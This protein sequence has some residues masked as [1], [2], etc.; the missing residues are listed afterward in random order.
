MSRPV[1][2]P[3][4]PR[5]KG[6]EASSVKSSVTV[7]NWGGGGS[8]ASVA[9]TSSAYTP[10]ILDAINTRARGGYYPLIDLAAS[11]KRVLEFIGNNPEIK[12]VITKVTEELSEI[13]RREKY[14]NPVDFVDYYIAQMLCLSKEEVLRD[15]AGKVCDLFSVTYPH[16]SPQLYVPDNAKKDLFVALSAMHRRNSENDHVTT[17]LASHSMLFGSAEERQELL[18]KAADKGYAPA[19]FLLA[20]SNKGSGWPSEEDV[21]LLS[22]AAAKGY[23]KAQYELGR[24]YE[25]RIPEVAYKVNRVLEAP[26]RA[27]GL[28]PDGAVHKNNEAAVMLF[29]LASDSGYAPAVLKVGDLRRAADMGNPDAQHSLAKSLSY[30]PLR[31]G[32][33][34]SEEDSTLAIIIAADLFRQKRARDIIEKQSLLVENDEVGPFFYS[35]DT[36]ST[37]NTKLTADQIIDVI[38]ILGKT[39]EI[40]SKRIAQN[41]STLIGDLVKVSLP[42]LRPDDLLRIYDG[43]RAVPGMDVKDNASCKAIDGMINPVAVL[44]PLAT[45]GS[46]SAAPT[47]SS[48]APP[49]SDLSAVSAVNPL[50]EALSMAL[51]RSGGSS[52]G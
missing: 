12:H 23:A 48:A 29:K 18:T 22:E 33:S 14:E 35:V 40:A 36:E 4:P 5:Q 25:I 3:P 41:Q 9:A 44:N 46:F 2:T 16:Y 28:V 13:A 52:K 11:R 38:N 6:G 19:Q 43:L 47:S 37:T 10:S 26:Y 49:S 51:S 8:E 17:L 39:P 27:I 31:Y 42:I 15:K 7:P 50:A 21:A 24:C 32:S 30:G 34:G 20:T 45:A 1:P